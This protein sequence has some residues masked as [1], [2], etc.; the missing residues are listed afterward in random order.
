MAV[1]PA[2]ERM[3]GREEEIKKKRRKKKEKEKYI[4]I[5]AD[6]EKGECYL[7]E[8]KQILSEGCSSS[9]RAVSFYG[10]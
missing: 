2:D 3:K 10:V 5:I 6:S 9:V 8:D 1:N 4:Y 7:E